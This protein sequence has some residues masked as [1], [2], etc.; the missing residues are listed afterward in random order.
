M[1]IV[2]KITMFHLAVSDLD[3][4]KEFY[5]DKLG[6]TAAGGGQWITLELPGGGTS[7]TLTTFHEHM[8]PGALKLYLSSPD[9]EASLKELS[10]KGITPVKEGHDWGTWD[11]KETGGKW[12][13]V[14]DPDGNHIIIVPN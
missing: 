9:V 8:K 12:F 11:G 10:A 5:A 4:A 7:I 6:L 3:K 14:V 2:D 13:E 1:P